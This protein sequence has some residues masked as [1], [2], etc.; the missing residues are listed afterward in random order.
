MSVNIY[1]STILVMFRN[2]ATTLF[3]KTLTLSPAS[4]P[5]FKS[6]KNKHTNT[7]T[8]SHTH[9]HTHKEIKKEIKADENL[10]M[11][12]ECK[13]R[14]KWCANALINIIVFSLTF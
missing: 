12:K 10:W 3:T 7:H 14:S 5:P 8:H 9:T 13:K 6:L 11:Q 2:A 4:P 1:K